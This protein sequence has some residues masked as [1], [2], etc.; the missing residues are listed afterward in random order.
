MNIVLV[1][2]AIDNFSGI[3]FLFDARP[4]SYSLMIVQF[5]ELLLS[6]QAA[7]SHTARNLGS[8]TSLDFSSHM[9]LPLNALF[10]Q[11]SLRF[12][13]TTLR[14][15]HT[16]LRFNLTPLGFKALFSHTTLRFNLT[17]LSF[18]ALFS[19]A[20]LRFHA[21]FN[22]VPL[23][24]NTLFSQAPLRFNALF[25]QAPLRL[26]VWVFLLITNLCGKLRRIV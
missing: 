25:S 22:Q 12:R 6:L 26:L 16:T 2:Q 1:D 21:L 19:Q 10:S 23:R 13:H 7:S 4:S 9:P 20:P 14:F 24:F 17:P 18:K 15:S 8:N 3:S 11:S 5:D